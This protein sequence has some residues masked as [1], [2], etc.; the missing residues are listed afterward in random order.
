MKI[1][2]IIDCDTGIDD[3]MALTLACALERIDIRGVTVTAGNAELKY[4]LAN[5]LNVM[6]LLNFSH[7]PVAAGAEKPLKRELLTALNVHG[8]DGL[9][10]YRFKREATD[11]LVEPPAWDFMRSLL[12]KSQKK[13]TIIAL[14]PLTNIAVLL[15]KYPEVK[16]HI[17]KIVFMGASAHTGNPTP[18]ATF[19]VLV[20]PEAY[21][22]VIFSGV[23]FDAVPLDTTRQAYLSAGEAEL[24]RGMDNPVARMVDG[25]L[26]GY[27]A[28]AMDEEELKKDENRELEAGKR[29][30]KGVCRLHDPAVIAYVAAPWL[31][32]GKKYYADVECKGELT[33]GYTFFDLEDYYG[34][35]EEEKNVFLVETIDREGF[36]N[37][38]LEA[39]R[40]YK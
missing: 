11:A 26:G 15:D 20:D 10:G 19:N 12:L 6:D 39:I 7:V 14:G 31:F 9:R 5:T 35:R 36:V 17:E 25:I 37:M 27:G 1:P 16:T 34:K 18:M 28:A 22:Q 2:V 29:R 30:F 32:T 8:H 38:F 13:L 4:T 40:S 23:L 33:T 3:A 21:R 24:I